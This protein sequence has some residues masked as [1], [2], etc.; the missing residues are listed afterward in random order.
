MV[1]KT[2]LNMIFEAWHWV[3]LEQFFVPVFSRHALNFVSS[4]FKLFVEVQ[5]YRNISHS[6]VTRVTK[7][8]NFKDKKGVFCHF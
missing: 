4:F 7:S 1:T 3:C 8:Q 5:V 6:I 2:H